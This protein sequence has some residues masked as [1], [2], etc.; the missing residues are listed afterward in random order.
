MGHLA[1]LIRLREAAI[2]ALPEPLREAA[3]QLD[4]TPFPIQR[5]IFTETAPIK[6]FQQKLLKRS[7]S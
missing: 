2:K 1:R 6:D 5:R 3:R 7:D 4:Q